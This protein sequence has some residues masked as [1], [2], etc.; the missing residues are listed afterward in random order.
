VGAHR[1]LDRADRVSDG[2]D[3]ERGGVGGDDGLRAGGG[4]R[5]PEHRRLQLEPLWQ[6]LDQEVGVGRRLARARRGG[7]ARPRLG[8]LGRR[9]QT[10][11]GQQR[12]AGLGARQRSLRVARV[13]HDLVPAERVLAADLRAHQ[14][15]SHDRHPHGS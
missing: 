9:A 7:H 13:Q 10:V 6:R 14:P 12:K 8:H 2:R 11:L 4:E 15:R 1:P 3:R 5:D